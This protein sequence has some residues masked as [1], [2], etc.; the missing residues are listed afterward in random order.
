MYSISERHRPLL[1]MKSSQLQVSLCDGHH[2]LNT[3]RGLKEKAP[4]VLELWQGSIFIRMRLT[5]RWWVS[6]PQVAH[7]H[8]EQGQYEA[9]LFH[10][11]SS[12]GWDHVRPQPSITQALTITQSYVSPCT[13]TDPQTPLNTQWYSKQTNTITGH[14]RYTPSIVRQ[15]HNAP[16]SY[17]GFFLINF[18]VNQPHMVVQLKLDHVLKYY[19]TD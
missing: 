4:T 2:C 15:P 5:N 10:A 9:E 12:R 6:D 8:T 1:D 3:H 13:C 17:C 11:L 16:Y 19:T 18:D 7:C 14:S